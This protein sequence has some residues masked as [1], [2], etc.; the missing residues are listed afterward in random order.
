MG[1]NMIKTG[2]AAL[3]ALCFSASVSIAE[4][5]GKGDIDW[6]GGYVTG[7][8][9]GTSRPTGNRVKDRLNAIRAAEATAQRALC[10]KPLKV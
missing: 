1:K 3:L 5:Q 6:A 10:L 9:F 7:V 2:I 8:G 4:E